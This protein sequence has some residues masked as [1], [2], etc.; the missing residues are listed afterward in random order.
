MNGRRYLLASTLIAIGAVSAACGTGNAGDSGSD[1]AKQPGKGPDGAGTIAGVDPR[2]GEGH[3]IPPA[4]ENLPLPPSPHVVRLTG[5]QWELTVRDLLKLDA[6]PGLSSTFPA[7]PGVSHEYFGTNAE[8]IVVTTAHRAAFESASE[9]VSALAVDTQAV[10]DRLFPAA[11]RDTGAT[12]SARI[13][14]FV[15]EFL[16]RAYRRPVTAAEI[17]A[18]I[19]LGD[20]A[21]QSDTTS[22]PFKIRARWILTAILQSPAFLYRT[23]LGD[24]TQPPVRGRMPLSPYELASKLSYALWGTM[25]NAHLVDLAKSGALSTRAGVAAAATEMLADP[26]AAATILTFHDQLMFMWDYE[27]NL[28]GKRATF[29]ADY[30]QFGHDSVEDLHMTVKDLFID[31]P[32][33]VRELYT[34]RTAYVNAGMAGVYGIPLS[35]IPTVQA[36]PNA[37]AKVEMDG[38]TRQGLY[39]HPGWLA[40]EGSPSDPSIIRRGAYLARHVLCLPLGNPPPEAGGK[41]PDQV[42]KPTNRERVA[43]ITKGCGDGCHGG[44]GGIINPLGFGLEGFDS[45]GVYR[46]V[47]KTTVDVLGNPLPAPLEVPVDATSTID[48]LG[49]F[50]GARTLFQMASESTHAH[51]CYAA[52]WIAYLNGTSKL[53]SHARWLNPAI[54][55]SI[56]GGSVRDIIVQL[57]Q[58]DAFLT[59]SR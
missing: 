55:T 12:V 34:S 53:D 26:Q 39:L 48:V 30:A 38:T 13:E 45:L 40:Y 24:A 52:H 46:T 22:D 9:Q 7:D 23:D 50:D 44:A 2:S 37:W 4:C 47:Q 20:A 21:V 8:D 5:A 42:R 41:S 18:A 54:A 33:G 15:T 17:T 56:R 29:A 36:N 31:H 58:T 57:V 28:V 3:C 11:A 27:E 16:P 32:G 43:E 51:A 25:P 6:A 59:V 14:A 19:A 10:Y 49:S 35:T 1:P